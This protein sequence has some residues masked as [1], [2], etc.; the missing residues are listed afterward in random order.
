MS[1]TPSSQPTRLPQITIQHDLPT[2]LT[3][4]KQGLHAAEDC[5]VSC[6][7]GEGKSVHGKVRLSEAEA[8]EG[9]GGVEA[10]ARDGVKAEL[11][12]QVSIANHPVLVGQA[13]LMLTISL[14]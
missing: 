14:P 1:S 12:R 5:W 11:V 4:I 2:V 10:T 7:A 6:Y 3:E 9:L 13:I 8:G